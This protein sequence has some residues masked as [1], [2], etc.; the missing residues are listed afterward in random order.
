MNGVWYIDT[1]GSLPRSNQGY[2]HCSIVVD[3]F[4]RK[5]YLEPL[6]NLSSQLVID[7]L[8]KLMCRR[9]YP[10]AIS[11]DSEVF[12]P[13]E[14]S[15]IFFRLGYRDIRISPFHSQ[16]NLSEKYVSLFRQG[17]RV[18]CNQEQSSWSKHLS[19]N[20]FSINNAVSSQTNYF[21]FHLE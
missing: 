10:T 16:S 9:G 2:K 1:I 7:K 8:F 18:Y 20:E 15:G 12:S 14:Y 3:E 21:S 19:S 6:R 13:M 5:T 4:S 11:R 17:L